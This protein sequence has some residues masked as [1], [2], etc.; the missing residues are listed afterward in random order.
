MDLSC[1]LF[2]LSRAPGPWQMAADEAL[3]EAASRGQASLRFYTWDQTTLSL[4]YFQPAAD[5]Q[6]G[7]LAHL[8]WVRRASGG[9]ALVHHHEVTYALALPATVA[10][11]ALVPSPQRGPQTPSHTLGALLARESW[12]GKMHHII[13][14]ALAALGV[15]PRLC[16]AHEE[17]QLGPVL[18]FLHHTSGDLLID[19]AKV[20]GSAQR[21]RKGSLMQHGGILLAQS[22]HTP[23]LPG[24]LELTGQQISPEEVALVVSRQ[25]IQDTG[26]RL[27]AGDWQEEVERIEQLRTRYTDP[28]WNARR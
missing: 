12:V 22:P 25:F 24:I 1:R 5:R 10:S 19:N 18:C 7:G 13:A 2:P 20:V 17:Q 27:Q 21:K 28:A 23:S 16:S 11:S 3:L 26:I 9:A 6:A 8:A 14:R 4:G 15:R